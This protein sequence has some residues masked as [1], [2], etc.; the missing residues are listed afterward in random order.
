MTLL[1]YAVTDRPPLHETPA[2]VEGAPVWAISEAG[3]SALVSR[4]AAAPAADEPSAWAYEQVVESA[5]A[6]AAVLPMRFGSTLADRP[7]VARWL[8]EQARELSSALER[9]RGRVE[10]SVRA[11]WDMV[12][13]AQAPTATGREYMQARLEPERRARALRERIGQALDPLAEASHYRLLVRPSAPV[14]AAFLVD[15]RATEA[16]VAR[17]AELDRELDEADLTCTGPWPAYSF[18]GGDTA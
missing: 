4:H 1:V 8:G 9:V 18:V 14:T 2:G 7:S 5:M 13:G 11:E 15:G 3:L 16:F 10:V 17:A 6:Q 12:D